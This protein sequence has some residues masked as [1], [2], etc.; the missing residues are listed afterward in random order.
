LIS[1]KDV[2]QRAPNLPV[3]TT[4]AILDTFA[5]APATVNTEYLLPHEQA[6]VTFGRKPMINLAGH[7][8][9]ADPSWCA[10]A[11]YEAIADR[12]RAASVENADARIGA[13]LEQFVRDELRAHGVSALTGTYCANGAD[14]E[15]DA[16]IETM[17]TII[18]IEMKKKSLT[19]A[20]RG[21]DTLK[22]LMDVAK[23]LID[24][25]IQAAR[26][27]LALYR[28]GTITLHHER[29]TTVLERGDRRIERIALTHL[30]F[31][32]LQD[33]QVISHVLR[34]LAGA[35]LR[36]TDGQHASEIADLTKTCNKLRRVHTELE[37]HRIVNPHDWF[38][39]CWFLSLGHLLTM[40]DNVSSA[41]DLKRELF[42]AR[43]M[44]MGSLD[45]YFE[46]AKGK[47]LREKA[48]N[49]A[50]PANP[51]SSRLP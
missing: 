18:I 20:A 7:F 16:I 8:L 28:H 43:H 48:A 14:G 13:A 31:G 42:L 4:R 15:C 3:E 39:N 38:F 46:Y 40:L 34:L 6:K 47:A 37:Q 27:E 32:A 41:D 22:L 23:T 10:P 1:E 29:G 33:R 12:A 30:D 26:H 17:D 19:R 9:V 11:F 45:F 25:Q 44:T 5:H 50:R 36:S 51:S 35:A 49:G 2:Q 21:G 24:A